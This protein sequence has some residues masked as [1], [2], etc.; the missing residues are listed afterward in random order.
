MRYRALYAAELGFGERLTFLHANPSWHIARIG[1]ALFSTQKLIL[2]NNHSCA[3]PPT[4]LRRKLQC[5]RRFLWLMAL[6]FAAAW[7]AFRASPLSIL[8]EPFLPRLQDISS[9]Y[10]WRALW[11]PRP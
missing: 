5:S 6:S 4:F 11:V 3:L 1:A 8:L 2:L 7:A 10:I 9:K